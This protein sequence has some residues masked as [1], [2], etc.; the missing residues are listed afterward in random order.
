[1]QTKCTRCSQDCTKTRST[2]RVNAQTGPFEPEPMKSSPHLRVSSVNPPA[3]LDWAG[4]GSDLNRN[5]EALNLEGGLEALGGPE[6]PESL[7]RGAGAWYSLVVGVFAGGGVG[8]GVGGV[9]AVLLK[10][11]FLARESDQP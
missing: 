4:P 9:E 6:G 2:G 10:N 11:L 7:V 8:R 5:W 1:M 3:C